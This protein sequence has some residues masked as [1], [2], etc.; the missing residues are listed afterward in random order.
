[1]RNDEA[2][3]IAHGAECE[4][5]TGARG[6][7]TEYRGQ[8]LEGGKIGRQMSGFIFTQSTYSTLSTNQPNIP[9]TRN[10]MSLRLGVIPVGAAFQPRSINSGDRAT[11]FR[12][13]KATPTSN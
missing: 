11:S 5:E 7:M 13:W 12:G 9:A 1:M 3:S 10:A 6:Q 8:K 2:E 4:E